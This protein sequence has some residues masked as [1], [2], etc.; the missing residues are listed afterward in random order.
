MAEERDFKCMRCG[1]ILKFPYTKGVMEERRCPKCGSNSIRLIKDKD[2][3]PN[4]ETKY[5]IKEYPKKVILKGGEQVVL[6]P[7]VKNDKQKLIEFFSRIPL[8]DRMFLKEDVTDKNV[9]ESWIKNLDYNRVIPIIAETEDKKIIGDAT[10]HI[11]TFGWRRHVG[12][13][14]IVTDRE[15]RRQHLGFLLA[16]EIFHQAL[17]LKLEKVLAEM[18]ENQ[19]AAINVFKALGFVKEAVL[20]NHVMDLNG[21]KNNL[22]IMT[23]NVASLW[24]KISDIIEEG[25]RDMSGA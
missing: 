8:E 13:I 2:K 20:K 7:L 5:M 12:E 22:I 10:L 3:A 4:N 18:M 19:H 24:E 14:R 16:K 21:N 25:Y 11:R 23:Q 15:F 6:R 9:I 1:A 17:S